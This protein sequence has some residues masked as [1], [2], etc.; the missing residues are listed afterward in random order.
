MCAAR[1]WGTSS[2]ATV[3]PPSFYDSICTARGYKTSAATP[4]SKTGTGAGAATSKSTASSSSAKTSATTSSPAKPAAPTVP[5]KVYITAVPSSVK[6]GSRTSIFWNAVGVK[7]CLITS[8]DGSFG[9]STLYGA[10]STVALTGETVFSIVCI[11]PDDSQISN[12][13]KVKLAI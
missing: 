1:P 2:A 6:L 7:S 8:P 13:V 5:A 10:A 11:K 9:A 12:F 4:A 3:I